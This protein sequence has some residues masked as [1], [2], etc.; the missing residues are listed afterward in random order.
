MFAHHDTE[1]VDCCAMTC[2]GIFQSD[3]DRFLLQGVSPPSPWKRVWVHLCLPIALF[4]MA[5]YVAL[6]IPDV[7]LNEFLCWAFLLL[8]LAGILSQC[9]K[10]RIKRMEIRKDVLWY[11]YQLLQHRNDA[12]MSLDQILDQS[13]PDEDDGTYYYR[14]QTER[15]IGCSH[16][17]CF[18]IGCYPNDNQQPGPSAVLLAQ[19]DANQVEE[20]L[21]SC[22]YKFFC[23]PCCGMH[24]QLGGVCGMAQESREIETSLLPP[25]YRRLDYVTMQ[26]MMA[27]FEGIYNHRW[28]QFNTLNTSGPDGPKANGPFDGI[29]RLQL[30]HLSLLSKTILQGWV[31]LTIFLGVWSVVGPLFWTQFLKGQG[32]RHYFSFLDYI[33]YLASWIVC[34]GT[35]AIVVYFCQRHKPLELSVDAMI[36]YFACGFVLS[37]TASIFYEIVLGITLELAMMVFMI[38]FGIDVVEDNNYESVVAWARQPLLSM[39]FGGN[40]CHHFGAAAVSG[41]DDYL[42]VFGRDHPVIYSIYLFIASYFL[43]ALV[44]EICKYFGYRMME[45]PD[46]LGRKDLEDA[47]QAGVVV[48]EEDETPSTDKGARRVSFPHHGLSLEAQGANITVAMV[49]VALGFS[50]CEDLVYVFLYNG[51]SVHMEVYVMIARTIFPIHPIAAALQSIGVCERDVEKCPTRLGRILLPSVIFHGTYDFLMLWIDFLASLSRQ[52]GYDNQNTDEALESGGYAALA[53]YAISTILMG[54]ALYWCH[55]ESK[56]QRERLA[57]RDLDPPEADM[58]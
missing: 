47:A 1:R 55:K 2:C 34:F 42:L 39:G 3:R 24:V 27:Y 35:L 11:N 19:G 5:G 44:E 8:L 40:G 14:G 29:W 12:N 18:L 21:C 50:L 26:P 32:R 33:V 37:S 15:D 28:R 49:C 10:G 22:L 9:Q 53:S 16:P 17:Y 46:F 30:P 20:S 38:F 7:V 13:R 25:A 43:A 58:M 51:S 48:S 54:A 56:Q 31:A 45:H 6:H 36:K 23:R 41:G 52:D 4:L 57:A